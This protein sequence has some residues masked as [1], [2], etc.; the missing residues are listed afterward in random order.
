MTKPYYQ[1]VLVRYR[2][3]SSW[4][5]DQKSKSYYSFSKSLLL[6][7]NIW[8]LLVEK[9]RKNRGQTDGRSNRVNESNRAYIFK[10][11]LLKCN[12]NF[13]K[14]PCRREFKCFFLLNF[15]VLYTGSMPIFVVRRF[16]NYS[17]VI[18]FIWNYLKNF[19]DF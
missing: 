13:L 4:V 6:E 18:W 2:S 16:R 7:A 12:S 15:I 14:L 1:R 17:F 5:V 8:K 19:D 9:W 11:L 10:N 3:Q